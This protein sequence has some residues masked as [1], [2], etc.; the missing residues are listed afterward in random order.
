MEFAERYRIVETYRAGGEG[1]VHLVEDLR[2]AARRKVLK[3]YPPG[4]GAT[5][6]EALR[7]LDHP[8]LASILECGT[9]RGRPYLTRE[10]AEGGDLNSVVPL[11]PR[12]ATAVIVEVARALG[13]LHSRGVVHL[14]L[15]PGNVLRVRSDA[16]T[17]VK[18]ADFGLA[19]RAGEA[20]S[21]GTLFF[22]APEVLRREEIDGR[23]DLFSLGVL[24]AHLLHGAFRVDPADFYRD[25][26]QKAFLEAA[27][28]DAGAWPAHLRDLVARLTEADRTLRP[29][30]AP[31]VL[32]FLNRHRSRP[33]PVETSET[34]RSAL[35]VDPLAP[36][37]PKV[38]AWTAAA[39]RAARGEAGP[40][41]FLALGP[42]GCGAREAV[43]EAAARLSL[44]DLG[45]EVVEGGRCGT[46]VALGEFFAPSAG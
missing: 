14:D 12:E 4:G 15:K 42:D 17:P 40:R 19:S 46:P 16:P 26:P 7:G 31:E 29:A 37:R 41:L 3:V 27:R 5:E 10:F 36:A 28:I 22:A 21:G 18:L 25:F 39:L 30:R 6:F 44:S 20:A 13:Y 45:V 11:G 33:I 23:A 24:L 34:V 2:E 8:G 9:D 32:R 35:R 43:R 38:D 1:E